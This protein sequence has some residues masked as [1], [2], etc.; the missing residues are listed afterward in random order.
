MYW[1]E[2]FV[3]LAWSDNLW[4]WN[5]LLDEKGELKKVMTTR[6]GKFD[7]ALT[8]CGPPAL[9]TNKGILLLYN[10]KNATNENASSTLPKGSYSVGEV[11]FDLNNPEK[12]L[13][14]TDTYILKPTLAHEMTGQYAA[15]TTFS[16]GLVFFNKKWFL[17]YGTADSFVGLA[18]SEN[19]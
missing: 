12:I 5:P 19:K 17:Y 2:H 3:N 18:V 1:G 7:S 16:E 8:E 4:D 11:L 15:G 14:R 6:R 9:I 13:H 10:G